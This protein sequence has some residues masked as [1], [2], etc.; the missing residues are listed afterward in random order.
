[1]LELAEFDDIFAAYALPEGDA[2]LL[3]ASFYRYKTTLKFAVMSHVLSF[4]EVI[5]SFKSSQLL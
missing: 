2:S 4:Q 1:M 3:S 5:F